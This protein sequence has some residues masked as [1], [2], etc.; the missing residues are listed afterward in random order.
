LLSTANVE[1]KPTASYNDTRYIRVN[2]KVDCV[3]EKKSHVVLYQKL[4][5]FVVKYFD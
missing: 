5:Q 3:S 1:V 2:G 4:K